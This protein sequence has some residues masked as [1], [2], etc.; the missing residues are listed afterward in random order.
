MKMH[1]CVRVCV[2]SGR[3]LERDGLLGHGVAWRWTRRHAYGA[4]FMADLQRKQTEGARSALGQRT[5]R[6]IYE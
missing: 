2:F 1:V 6:F 3:E 5:S 4:G